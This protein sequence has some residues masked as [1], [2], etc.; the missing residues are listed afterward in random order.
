MCLERTFKAD[1]SD[2]RKTYNQSRNHKDYAD[3][4]TTIGKIPERLLHVHPT[5]AR[6]HEYHLNGAKIP[7]HHVASALRV[8][9]VYANDTELVENALYLHDHTTDELATTLVWLRDRFYG[10]VC[11]WPTL[12]ERKHV[13]ALRTLDSTRNV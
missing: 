7:P 8:A 1:V 4:F 6:A 5:L 12:D 2:A 11:G 13:T 10:D 3:F 9:R